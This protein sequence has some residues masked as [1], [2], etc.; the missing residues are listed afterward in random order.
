MIFEGPKELRQ[1][2][3]A[4]QFGNFNSRSIAWRRG[5]LSVDKCKA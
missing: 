3:T 1:Y 4:T 2:R 5:S